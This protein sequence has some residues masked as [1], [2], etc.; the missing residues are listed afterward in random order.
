MRLAVFEL[1]KNKKNLYYFLNFQFQLN[2]IYILVK[3]LMQL[4]IMKHQTC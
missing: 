3:Q 2:F 1:S 4:L